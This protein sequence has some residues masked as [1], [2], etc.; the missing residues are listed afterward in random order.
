MS[1]IFTILMIIAMILVLASLVIGIAGMIKG[2]EFN[3][4]H[5]NT[6]MRLR[7]TLQGVAL[8]FF[9]LAIMTSNSE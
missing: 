7:V 9:A 6:L 4:K 3:E 1:K 2:G 8:A 5:G